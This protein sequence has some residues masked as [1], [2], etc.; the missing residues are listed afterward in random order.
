MDEMVL[1]VR[2]SDVAS[3]V[4][5]YGFFKTSLDV[6]KDVVEKHG[7]F[8]RRS[9]AE[10]DKTLR[11]VIPYIILKNEEG[12]YIMMRRLSAHTEQ[13]LHGFYS[14]A[15][16]GHVNDTD[17]GNSPWLKF[18]SGMER[19]IEEEVDIE[20]TDWPQY[21]GIV[22]ENTTAVNTVHIGVVFLLRAKIK[23]IKEK[24]KLTMTLVVPNEVPKF[25]DR[26]ESWS[27]YAFEAIEEV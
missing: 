14:L 10:G 7:F 15:V 9:R 3:I 1:V 11:Q 21:I 6:V 23:G 26:L 12:L 22:R 24:E 4:D 5:G 20:R 27:R 2:D 13:R 8:V 19:E 18:L 16:G 17:D 25:Y